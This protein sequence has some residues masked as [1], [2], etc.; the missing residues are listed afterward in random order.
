LKNDAEMAPSLG[1]SDFATSRYVPGGHHTWFEGSHGELFDRVRSGW[2]DRRPGQGRED[3]SQVVIVPV[4]SA[5]FVS[6]TVRVDKSTVLHAGFERRQPHEEGYV[7]VTAEGEREPVTFASVVLYSADTLLENGGKRTTD[8]E[9]EVVALIAGPVEV[10]PMDPL[11]MARNM[12]EKPGGTF[13]EYSAQE[14]AESIWYW[15]AR[16]KAHVQEAE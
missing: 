2:P 1:W 8:A 13:C 4:D 11:T 12:L 10:E 3:L 6:S 14:F 16:A 7:G 9:W 15:A 5:G